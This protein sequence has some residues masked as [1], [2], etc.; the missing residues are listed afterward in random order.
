MKIETPFKVQVKDNEGK[1]WT[2]GSVVSASILPTKEEGMI[3]FTTFFSK[4]VIP[5]NEASGYF[6]L[7]V[8]A[9]LVEKLW[10]GGIKTFFFLN[11]NTHVLYKASSEWIITDCRKARMANRVQYQ[12][13]MGKYCKMPQME[14]VHVSEDMYA[15]TEQNLDD[16]PLPPDL[17]TKDG[18]GAQPYRDPFKNETSLTQKVLVAKEKADAAVKSIKWQMTTEHVNLR[19]AI[20]KVF[21]VRHE[22][23]MIQSKGREPSK[24]KS[25][26]LI[27]ALEGI[28]SHIEWLRK[29]GKIT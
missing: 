22:Y 15:P 23:D 20:E 19:D 4:H 1:Y 27:R 28:P 13:P 9:D 29:E 12:I 21:K 26:D 25:E 6:C 10:F 16:L 18:F 5:I 3:Y 11:K 24:K 14:S 2:R 7:C 17:P 8:D